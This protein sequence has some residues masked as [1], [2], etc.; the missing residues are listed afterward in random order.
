M[1]LLNNKPTLQLTPAD[2]ATLRDFKNF[3][4]NIDNPEAVSFLL[5]D[6]SHEETENEYFNIQYVEAGKAYYIVSVRSDDFGIVSLGV[7]STREKAKESLINYEINNSSEIYNCWSD[8]FKA[9]CAKSTFILDFDISED[10]LD[11]M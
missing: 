4:E 9:Y 1:N 3:T 8:F 7:F 2:V 6:I 5:D 11:V 10:Y